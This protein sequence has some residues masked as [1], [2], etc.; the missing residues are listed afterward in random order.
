MDLPLAVSRAMNP[1]RASVALA[2]VLCLELQAAA[3][4][5]VSDFAREPA[6]SAMRLSPDGRR[7]AFMREVNGRR[8]VHVQEVDTGKLSY[9]DVGDALLANEQPKSVASFQWIGNRRLTLTT[10]V[11]DSVYGVLAVDENGDAM[12]PLTGYELGR[13]GRPGLYSFAT[14]VIHSF[15]DKDHHILMLD[16]H[17]GGPGDWNHPDILSVDTRTGL[18]HVEV[19]NP[20]EVAHWGIDFEGRARLGILSHGDLSGA[21]YRDDEKSPWRTILPLQDRTGQMRVIGF[22]PPNGRVFVAALTPEQ[23]WTVFP[24]DPKTG[25]MGEPLLSDPEYDIVP[26]RSPMLGAVPLAGPI[27]SHA[28]ERLVGVRYVT[29]APRVKWFDPEFARHQQAIDRAL[30]DTVNLLIDVSCDGKR[31]LW[32]GY[33]DQHPGTYLLLD[34]EKRSIKPLGLCM[35]WLHPAAMATTLAIKYTA[36]DGLVIHGFLTVPPGRELKG[37]PL[38]VRPHGGPWSRDVWGFDPL[39]Q[40]LASRG[41]AVLQMNYRGSPGYGDAL[42]R[43]ARREIGRAIQDDIEDGT[44]WALQAGIADPARVAIMGISYGG[45]SALFG[46]GRSTDLYRCG[47]SIAG[48]ADWPEIF[49]DRAGDS[50]GQASLRY[51]RREI[52]DPDKDR[53]FL[54]SISPVNFADRLTA[55]VLL[56][57]GK[58]DRIVPPDQARRMAGA[59]EKA[60]RKPETLFVPG[61]GHNYGH[62]DQRLKIYTAIVQFLD[63]HLGGPGG[64]PNVP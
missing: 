31:Q 53:A 29:D 45:Y 17:V 62:E 14:E 51:W 32:F 24:L 10:A 16:R 12:R 35:P 20:G 30:P 38:V 11:W 56:I 57:H 15:Q 23:R 19:K 3:P 36:R 34:L 59:L 13:V 49:A 50:G 44:R 1:L 54:A 60:G 18:S 58:E 39:L 41:Y 28:P 40:L 2:S 42:R 33:A 26:E 22:D 37:L 55:P 5:P 25:K 46:L 43:K 21:I 9:L 63:R 52:G 4:P 61:L 6:I 8:L 48:V 64:G 47:I 27:F 7:V